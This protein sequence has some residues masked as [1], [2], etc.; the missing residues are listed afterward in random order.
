[1]KSTSSTAVAEYIVPEPWVSIKTAAEHFELSTR[2]V[3]RMVAAG[4][5]P[6]LK[7]GRATRVRLSDVE[8]AGTLFPA[9]N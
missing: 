1:M 2:A 8:A 3:E 7:M 5:I 4:T 9:V 6:V